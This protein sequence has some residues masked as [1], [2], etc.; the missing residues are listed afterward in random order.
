[1]RR[2]G[3]HGGVQDSCA[4]RQFGRREFLLFA[5]SGVA[6]ALSRTSAAQP[7]IVPPRL[8]ASLLAKV[9]SYDRKFAARAGDRAKLLL[10]SK[11]ND[12]ESSRVVTEMTS[13][14]GSIDTVGGLPHDEEVMEFTDAAAIATTCK[15]HRIAAVYFGPGLGK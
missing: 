5:S 9:A 1:M 2:P 8:Q 11:V 6:T 15:S 3:T 13:A 10:I 4:R 12:A 14:L 7:T